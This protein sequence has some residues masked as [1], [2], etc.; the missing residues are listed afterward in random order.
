MQQFLL[1]SNSQV[2]ANFRDFDY[3][4]YTQRRMFDRAVWAMREG[5]TGSCVVEFD[6][7]LTAQKVERIARLLC[8]YGVKTIIWGNELNDP[9]T[10][11]RDNLPALFDILTAAAATIRKVGLSGIDLSMAGLA[12]YGHGEYL[13]KSIRTFRELQR[14]RTPA[15]PNDL[16]F[17]R[18]ADHYYG[19]VDGLLQRIRIMRGIMSGEGVTQLK[20]D[21]TEMGNPTLEPNQQRA[22]DLQLAE[23][24]I[25]QVASIAIGS[26]LVDRISFY[27]LAD[28]SS[29]DMLLRIG[30]TPKVTQ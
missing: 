14:K 18:V 12:Y 30:E 1:F 23:G 13:Q 17:Q 27:S 6:R 20:Y 29:I 4:E 3:L 11:W 25:P 19:P 22:S 8:Y 21:L 16:P 10:P 2:I 7:P 5:R 28:I 15:S 26:N 9:S 24:Y